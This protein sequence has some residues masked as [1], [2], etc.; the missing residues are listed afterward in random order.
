MNRAIFIVSMMLSFS[1][2]GCLHEGE[3][4][5]Q[6]EEEKTEP[7]V[8]EELPIQFPQWQAN[9]H[10][11]TMWNNSMMEG[12]AWVAYFSAPWCTHC[13]ATL[14][15]YDQVIPDGKY[16]IFS[17]EDDPQYINMSDWHQRTEENLNRSINRPFIYIE[18]LGSDIGVQAIPHAVFINEE[19]FVYQVEVG[20]RTNQ[21]MI[22]E[23]WNET[24]ADIN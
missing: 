23:L 22:S 1:L 16:V 4:R 8:E 20:R 9:D 18:Q 15:A 21:T 12:E 24:I 2:A 6:E 7:I 13:E 11:S 3:V 19:G 17:N 14:D 5:I 10:N